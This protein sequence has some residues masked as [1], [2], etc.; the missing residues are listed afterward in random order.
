MGTWTFSTYFPRRFHSSLSSKSVDAEFQRNQI[1]IFEQICR[2][3]AIHSEMTENLYII[4]RPSPRILQAQACL[5]WE[6][7]RMRKRLFW[8]RRINLRA[9]LLE[10]VH[11]FQRCTLSK[12]DF[13]QLPIDYN[14]A[15][16]DERLRSVS[17]INNFSLSWGEILIISRASL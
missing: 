7:P 16:I 12:L 6:R 1:K 3:T 10:G 17:K 9:P 11:S 4:I 5:F 14:P 13:K 15:S 2:N 8:L